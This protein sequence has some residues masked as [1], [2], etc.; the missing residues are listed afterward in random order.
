MPFTY[1][2]FAKTNFPRIKPYICH[3]TRLPTGS[4]MTLVL[5]HSNHSILKTLPFMEDE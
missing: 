2:W 1:C 5:Q 3:S 4:S